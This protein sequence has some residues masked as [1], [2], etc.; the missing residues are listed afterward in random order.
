R[1]LKVGSL[2]PG[3]P[4]YSSGLDAGDII[5]KVDGLDTKDMPLPCAVKKITG[6]AGTV[7][8]WHGRL[9]HTGSPNCSDR[10]RM[11]LIARLSRKDMSD[12]LFEEP[13]DLWEYY[14]ALQKV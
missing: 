9:F 2:L 11:A 10:I 6:P 14:P 8:F 5:E 13:D 7:C 1:M 3:T 12:I 4:A